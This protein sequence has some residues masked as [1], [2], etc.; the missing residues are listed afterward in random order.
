MEGSTIIHIAIGLVVIFSAGL[1]Q[2]ITSFGFS[3][4]AV[5][6]LGIFLPLKVVVP[7]LVIYSLIMNSIILYYIR[8]HINIKKISILVIAGIVGTPFG[9]HLLTILDE[10]MLKVMVG[11]IVTISAIIN[12]YG[13]RVRVK[14]ESL[15][16]I[17]VGLVSGLLNGSVSLSGPP[18]IVFLTNQG[19][20]KQVFRA[21][22]TSYFWILN[23]ITIPTFFLSG[24]I[25]KNVLSYTLYLFPGLIAGVLLGLKLGNK[26]NEGYFK[27]LTLGL[28]TFMG[29]LSIVSGIR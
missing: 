6:L 19:V 3:L 9:T 7:I 10:N 23:I 12:R 8:E 2:G 24:L 28:V 4:L 15:S 16:Y 5:P 17:P 29:I 25:T 27:R 11:V 1:I 14:N 21:N 20:E 13:Y 18:I 26:V 22:L